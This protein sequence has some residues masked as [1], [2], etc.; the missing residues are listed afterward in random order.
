MQNPLNRYFATKEIDGYPGEGTFPLMALRTNAFYWVHQRQTYYEGLSSYDKLLEVLPVNWRLREVYTP[1]SLIYGIQ[2]TFHIF[3][4]IYNAPLGV[5]ALPKPNER[6]RGIHAV[7]VWGWANNLESLRFVNSWGSGWGDKGWGTI[8]REYLNKYLVEIWIG[9]NCRIGLTRYN[10]ARLE[11]AANNREYAKA[12]ML[13]N[14]RYKQSFK[15]RGDRYHIYNYETIS[16]EHYRPVFILELRNGYGLRIAWLHFI[17]LY[18]PTRLLI[19][20]L[21]VFPS[22]QRLG[23]GSILESWATNTA[24]NWNCEKVEIQFHDADAQPRVRAAGRLF[25]TRRGYTWKWQDVKYPRL[26]AIGEKTL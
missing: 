5:V 22:F 4:S 6:P 3:E 13:E 18:N 23:F 21:Y 26:Q 10:W 12:W 15:Y 9:R 20:E 17:K 7:A 24:K 14:P 1:V 11:N 16:I 19:T 25:G 8:S 2:I